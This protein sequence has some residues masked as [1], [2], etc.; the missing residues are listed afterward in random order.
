MIS[1]VMPVFNTGSYL[2]ESVGSIIAQSFGEWEL[3]LIDDA[4]DDKKTI[5]ILLEYSSADHRI[6]VYRLN[7][8]VGAGEARNIGI[9]QAK[10]D[11]VLFL[12]SDDIFDVEM[13]KILYDDISRSNADMCICGY[14]SFD[15]L[16]GETVSEF[17][18]QEL[19]GVTDR[20]FS[21]ADLPDT[22]FLFWNPGP[23][24]KIYK[25]EFIK[26][27]NI[28]FQSLPSSNDVYFSVI[29]AVK[30]GR[31]V[32]SS[33][34]NP[35]QRYRINRT[36]QISSNKTPMNFNRA[37]DK[38][39][40]EGCIKESGMLMRVYAFWMLSFPAELNA[41]KDE[42]ENKKAYLYLAEHLRNQVFDRSF[43][44]KRCNL[45]L[46][47]F[48][49]E[50]DFGWINTISDYELQLEYYREAIIKRLESFNDKKIIVWGYGKRGQ[51]FEMFCDKYLHRKIY[52][53]DRIRPDCGERTCYGNPVISPDEAIR[54]ADIIVASNNAVFES[55]RNCQ[56]EIFAIEKYCPF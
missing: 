35:L 7:S 26:D 34:P 15:C 41:S 24:N 37:C 17:V 38:L 48:L 49:S 18:P 16:T 42:E 55:L 9:K 10:G 43:D 39:V 47:K 14:E 6:C 36:G 50:D 30:A 11:Y 23:C 45:F 3:L 31:I 22:G 56:K 33:S 44:D 29:C 53:T 40:H 4:S 21:V 54:L 5:D 27:N 13:L 46:V 32:Y 8:R 19:K 25:V 12:D 20:A 52:V 1:I 28:D 2:Y 51:A